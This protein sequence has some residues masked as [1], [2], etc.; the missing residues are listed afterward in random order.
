MAEALALAERMAGQPPQALRLAKTLMRHGSTSSYETLM[1][2]SA[3]A[4]AL[5]HQTEDHMEG[6]DAILEKRTPDFKGC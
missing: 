2:M 1:E 5:M 6:V 4:Q 3:A